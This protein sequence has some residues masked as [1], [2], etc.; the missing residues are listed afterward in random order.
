[1]MDAVRFVEERNRM[2]GSFGDGCKGCPA[3]NACEDDLYAQGLI[4]MEGIKRMDELIDECA[5]GNEEE[6]ND[7]G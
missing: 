5:Y 3:F 7:N 1:M 4:T 6:E 2:C